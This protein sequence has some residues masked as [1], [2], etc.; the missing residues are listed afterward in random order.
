[1][2]LIELEIGSDETYE[3]NNGKLKPPYQKKSNSRKNQKQL[4]LIFEKRM[5]EFTFDI[6][7]QEAL[8]S[9]INPL[10]EVKDYPLKHW[11][12]KHWNIAVQKIRD[13]NQSTAS[14]ED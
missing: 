2:V 12:E 11:A 4:Q 5:F 7:L 6:V 13:L 3:L 10:Q 9:R 8:V 1:M 14:M